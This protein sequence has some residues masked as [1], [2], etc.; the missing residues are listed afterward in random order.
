MC[1]I[2]KGEVFAAVR[3]DAELET[4]LMSAAPIIFDLNPDILT[5]KTRAEATHKNKK[6]LFIHIDLATGIGKDKSGLVYAKEMG[7]DGIISTR[8]NMIKLAREL[9]FLT[10]Q[11]FFVV[12]SHSVKTT[13]ES[14]KA[15]KADMIEVM[16]GVAVKP[17]KYLS[18]ILDVPVIAGGLIESWDEVKAAFAAGAAA[19]STGCSGLW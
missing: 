11:R 13:V 7:A 9:G 19:V 17:I 16:P 12:D 8:T 6:R 1:D 4:A 15:S 10:V 14:L 18:T 5:L 2:K 3:T